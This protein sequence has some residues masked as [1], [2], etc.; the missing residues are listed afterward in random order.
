[1]TIDFTDAFDSVSHKLIKKNLKS[2]GFDKNFIN[3]ILLSYESSRT[4]IVLNKWKSK[5]LFFRKG[6]KKWYQLS[7]TLFNICIESLLHCLNNCKEDGYY[8]FDT[9]TT[10][11]AYAD[12]IIFSD[13]AR[14]K[15]HIKVIYEFCEYESN[16]KI[17]SKKCHSFTYIPCNNS[18]CVLNDNFI[19][20]GG[21]VNIIFILWFWM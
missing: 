20:S 7:P 1:M 12:D 18:R 21:T 5:E 15:N 13:T 6:F 2:I 8:W 16:M 3:S 11:Q 17:N 10:I 9:S 4:R 14:M 19:I